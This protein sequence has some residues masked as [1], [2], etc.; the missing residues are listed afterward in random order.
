MPHPAREALAAAP[1]AAHTAA[2]P[3]AGRRWTHG[4]PGWGRYAQELDLSARTDVV[5]LIEVC[6]IRVIVIICY[7]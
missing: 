2:R 7:S 3:G 4:P 5:R 6:N 1:T